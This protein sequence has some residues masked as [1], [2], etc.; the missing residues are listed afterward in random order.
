MKK[1]LNES[2]VYLALLRGVN[3][4]GKHRLPMKDLA[5]LC[6]EIGA[7]DVQTVI[8]SGNVVFRGMDELGRGFAP[9]LSD[10]LLTQFGI[11]V[12]VVVRTRDEW[13]KV[14]V[15]NPFLGRG[16]DPASLHVA[17]LARRPSRAEVESLDPDRSPPD[18]FEVRDT[19]IFL[20]LPNG[21][22]RSR[23]DTRYFDQALGTTST[24]RNW[25]TVLRL[26]EIALAV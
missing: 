17:F 11:P 3:V 10:G 6:T 25:R 18:V 8:Q 2:R 26:H 22:A 12:P 14:V 23:L 4:G 1:D 15:G 13:T 24:F 21:A 9:K 7:R 5:R 16:A 20:R 19:E